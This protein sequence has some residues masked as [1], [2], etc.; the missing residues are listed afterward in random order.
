MKNKKN[1]CIVFLILLYQSALSSF[2]SP[3]INID[4]M[5]TNRINFCYH[6]H[7]SY[8]TLKSG[9]PIVLYSKNEM[10]NQS[11]FYESWYTKPKEDYLKKAKTNKIVHKTLF[12]TGAAFLLGGL[13][14]GVLEKKTSYTYG[15]VPA[16]MAIV[17]VCFTLFSIPFKLFENSNLRKAKK[18]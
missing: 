1:Y 5:K 16:G 15:V 6:N 7:K 17:G 4:S 13:I 3:N 14:Y 8:N 18:L 11:T 10:N 9:T 2:Q 12:Y